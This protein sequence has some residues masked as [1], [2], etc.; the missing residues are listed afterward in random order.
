MD[1]KKPQRHTAQMARILVV[2]DNPSVRA[3]I[4]LILQIDGHDAVLVE[5]G[6]DGVRVLESQAVDLLIADVFM[7]EMDGFELIRFV[8][9]MKP[10]LPIIAISGALLESNSRTGPD[11]LGMAE[12]LGAVRTIRKPFKPSE[13]RDA[14]RACLAE[15][16]PGE[17]ASP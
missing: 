14:M 2:D 10:G 3:T 4:A 7:P 1:A 12:A 5:N 11:F 9:N 6:R 13:L 15:A 8:Q 17:G 16:S